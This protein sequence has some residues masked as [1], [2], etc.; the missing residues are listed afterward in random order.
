MSI[1]EAKEYW[2]TSIGKNEEFDHNSIIIGNID[3]EIPNK[4]KIAVCSFQG[5][6]RIFEP[7]FGEFKLEHRLFEKNYGESLLQL[8]LGNMIINSND[9]QLVMLFRKRIHVVQFYNLKS[10]PTTKLCIEHK[11]PRSC[12]SFCMGRIGDQQYDILFVQSVD[13]VIS[14]IEQDSI[15]N[16]VELYEMIIPGCLAYVDRK[17]YL[18]LSNPAY[19]IECYTYNN[20]AT[21]KSSKTGGTGGGKILHNWIVNVGEL[22]NEIY[23]INNTNT[24]KQEIYVMTDTMIF[25]LSDNGSILYQKKLDFEA[26]TSHIY[27]I[28][29]SGYQQ[30][31]QVNFMQLVSTSNDHIMVYK[32]PNLAWALK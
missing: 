21:L 15:V 27:N 16:H 28:D 1:F 2:S 4:N 9:K 19:E 20:L 23:V 10:V 13:G 11:M 8:G 32:G 3:N 30:N 24:K 5:S 14:I 31:K 25:V 7:M 18:V 29:D 22:V 6:L 12:Y 17:D 26:I